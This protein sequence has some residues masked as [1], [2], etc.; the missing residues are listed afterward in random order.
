V[1]AQGTDA[2]GNL[3]QR[4][5]LFGVL[6]LEHHM[7]RV[8][9]RAGD[10]PVEIVGLEIEG[11]GVGE[12]AREFG[13]DGAAGRFGEADIDALGSSGCGRST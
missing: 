12:K 11:V 4:R 1:D 6:L 5:P 13:G 8:E 2:L 10:V 7:Q 3:V 9:H